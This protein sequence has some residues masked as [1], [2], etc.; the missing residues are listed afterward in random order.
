MGTAIAM[1]WACAK[2][3]TGSSDKISSEL[4]SARPATARSSEEEAELHLVHFREGFKPKND[5]RPSGVAVI[6][7]VFL[8]GEQE[9]EGI[10]DLL[11][12]ANSFSSLT[13]PPCTEGV[14]WFVFS[15]PKLISSKQLASLVGHEERP[16]VASARPVQPKN[17]RKLF[18]NM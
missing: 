18:L 9:L 4:Q 17:G 2:E 12:A 15:E 11:T 8:V 10:E 1:V 5:D 14:T 13:T 16:F 3:A 7:V 6:A